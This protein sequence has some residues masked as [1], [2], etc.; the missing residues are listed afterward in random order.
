[1]NVSRPTVLVISSGYH[2]YR[3]YLL[4]DIAE[5]ADVWLLLDREPSWERPYLVGSSL[6]DTLDTGAVVAA[7]E[8]V[9]AGRRLG[10]VIC[11]DE[12]RM[13][14]TA[15]V[16]AALGLPGGEVEAVRRCRDKHLTRTSLGLHGVPQPDSVV[17][18]SVD[19]AIDAGRRLGYP[20]VVKPR[21][22]GASIGVSKAAMAAELIAGYEHA[23]AAWEDGVP[24][25]DS[26][27]IE[28]CVSGTEISVDCAVVDG[29]AHPMFL[30]RKQLGFEPYCEEVGHVVDAGD[31]LLHSPELRQLLVDA[32]RAVGLRTAI[33]HTEIMLSADGPKIIEINCRFGGDLI[34]YVASVATGL[35]P[36]RVAVAVA[37]GRTPELAAATGGVAR[38]DF[39]YPEFDAVVDT[40]EVDEVKTRPDIHR[41]AALAQPGQLLEL[42]PAGH[43]SGRYGYVVTTGSTPADCAAAVADACASIRLTARVPACPLG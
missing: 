20:V 26:V 23:S 13:I 8:L 27:L 25:S 12:L 14:N 29:V 34:P 1:M 41:V 17:V 33:T 4:A 42:P 18:G 43:V 35:A 37:T 3:E 40:V 10:G 31:P 9:A 38:I 22:L 30:A 5:H 7:A 39:L 15:A 2:L 11:W 36:G 19:D 28:E 16:A 24:P 21:G 32:H 6:V